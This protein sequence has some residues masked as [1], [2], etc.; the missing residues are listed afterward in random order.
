MWP[1]SLRHCALDSIQCYRFLENI[2]L[3]LK[4]IFFINNDIFTY[5]QEAA[6]DSKFTEVHAINKQRLQNLEFAQSLM[7]QV[8]IY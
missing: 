7:N 2:L 8:N 6:I 3:H 5:L 1:K 4:S